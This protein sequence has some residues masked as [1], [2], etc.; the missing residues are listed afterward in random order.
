ML[1]FNIV[2]FSP[3]SVYTLV[4][5]TP[6]NTEFMEM[7]R[8]DISAIEALYRN[9]SEL[10]YGRECDKFV[11]D[12][13]FWSCDINEEFYDFEEGLHIIQTPFIIVPIYPNA[14]LQMGTETSEA[15]LEHISFA[16]VKSLCHT[17]LKIH[18]TIKTVTTLH[19]LQLC[20]QNNITWSN[21]WR[22]RHML[23]QDSAIF[24]QFLLT[25]CHSTV[26]ELTSTSSS[27]FLYRT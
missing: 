24:G 3:V 1:A 4:F 7:L 12:F 5:I 6:D 11:V 10:T 21:V 2:F 18:S 23:L 19:C 8:H 20:K 26:V 17:G 13:I 16:W 15:A 22:I 27:C 25:M 14:S 9:F